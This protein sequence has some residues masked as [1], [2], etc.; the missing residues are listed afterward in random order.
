MI[1][2]NDYKKTL[3]FA[4]EEELAKFEQAA[5]VI[6]NDKEFNELLK[7]LDVEYGDMLKNLED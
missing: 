5:K 3:K 6:E 2:W 7:D 4:N 1:N